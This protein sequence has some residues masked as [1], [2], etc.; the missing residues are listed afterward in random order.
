MLGIVDACILVLILVFA[1]GGAKRGVFKQTVVTVGTIFVFILSYYFKDYLANYF[2]YNLPFFNF[3]GEFTGLSTLNIIMYQLLAFLIMFILFSAVLVVLIKIT[4]VFEKILKFTIILGIP[5]KILG[6]I[7]GAIEG[8][9]VVFVAL[10]F[11]NQ[12][13]IDLEI[14]NES[15]AMPVIVNSS[16]VLSNVVSKTQDTII[17]IYDLGKGY[18]ITQD[19]NKF[20]KNAIDVMLKNK[21][22]TVNYVDVLIEKDKISISGINEIL[23]KYR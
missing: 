18:V 5:S 1:A 10:F 4:G 8:Y 16:P 11:L 22:I 23:N 12:P 21:I 7:L 13:A 3:A 15:K 17:E 14:L 6:F 2:S 19:K 9:I 20:N